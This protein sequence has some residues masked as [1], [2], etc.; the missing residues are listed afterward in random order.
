MESDSME[1]EKKTILKN[2]EPFYNSDT[3]EGMIIGNDLDSL[4][5]ASLL[6]DLYDW[7]I[8]GI[9]DYKRLWFDAKIENFVDKLK[10]K[11]YVAIDLDINKN[12]LPSIGHHILKVFNTDVLPDHR[13]SVNPNL[14]RG[15]TRENFKI[16]Y[17]LGTIHFMIWLHSV[18]NMDEKTNYLIWLADS[19]F[20]NGQSHRFRDNVK[21]WVKKYLVNKQFLEYADRINTKEFEEKLIKMIINDLNKITICNNSGQVTSKYLNIRGFQCQWKE[22]NESHEEIIRVLNYINGITK[23][24]K[25]GFPKE[26]SKFTGERKSIQTDWMLKKYESLDNFLDKEEVF[27][28]V[29]PSKKTLNYTS[30]FKNK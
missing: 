18:N 28:Y 24:V 16:K 15:I 14:I 22:P 2:F 30:R 4:L 25:P 9:Y 17:P 12:Y 8:I 13:N 29:L 19:A 1:F 11:K 6:K 5:S 26:F 21:E 23:W 20:I 10:A 3:I 27:S 7:D